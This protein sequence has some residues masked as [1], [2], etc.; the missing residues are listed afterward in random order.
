MYAVIKEKKDLHLSRKFVHVFYAAIWIFLSCF[1]SFSSLKISL[2]SITALIIFIDY[3]RLYIPQLNNIIMFFFAP[4]MRSSDV[5]SVSSF[6]YYSL[7][8]SFVVFFFSKEI[9]VPTFFVIG[10]ADPLAS[11]MGN[12]FGKKKFLP[13]K[14]YVGSFTC[15]FVGFLIYYYFFFSHGLVFSLIMALSV[16]LAEML[17]DTGIDD[18]LLVPVITSIA[19]YIFLQII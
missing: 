7:G 11:L 16:F 6:S 2:F 8:L 5:S 9:A 13:N 15:F 10:L 18:N 3:L 14:S 1:I 19:L 4:V 17:S 12:L